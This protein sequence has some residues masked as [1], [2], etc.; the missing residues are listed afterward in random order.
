MLNGCQWWVINVKSLKS[1]QI[2]KIV[3]FIAIAN[4]TIET[5]CLALSF[6]VVCRCFLLPLRNTI[7]IE[8][9]QWFNRYVLINK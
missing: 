5:I 3:F 4:T 7:T 8:K 1:A 6:I 9:N 2:E